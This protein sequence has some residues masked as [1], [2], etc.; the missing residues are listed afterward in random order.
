MQ[1][2]LG[3]E[4]LVGVVGRGCSPDEDLRGQIVTTT[5]TYTCSF[6]AAYK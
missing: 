2:S 6:A 4:E 3:K 5:T 1:N